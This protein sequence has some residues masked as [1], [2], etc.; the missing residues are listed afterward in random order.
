MLR[1]TPVSP[2]VALGRALVKDVDLRQIPVRTV[3]AERV[4]DELNRFRAAVEGARRE[5]LELK[6]RFSAR[7]EES[8][9]RI[10][11]THLAY[12]KDPVFISD[13]ENAVLNGAMNLESAIAKV[14]SDFDRIFKL[15][16]TDVLRERAMDLRDVAM[17]VLRHLEPAPDAPAGPAER[18]ILVTRELSLAEMFSQPANAWKG[19]VTEEGGVASHAAILA[20]SLRIPTVLGVEGI[21]EK[22]KDGDLVLVD[23]TEGVVR[24]NPEERLILE[25][26]ETAAAPVVEEADADLLLRPAQTADGTAVALLATCGN[27][28]EVDRAKALAMEGVGLYRTEL[29]YLLDRR[30]PSEDVLAEHY[31]KAADLVAPRPISFRLL[32][33]DATARLADLPGHRDPNPALG[34]RSIRML[35]ANPSVFRPQLRALLR[36]SVGRN[37]RVLVPF[38]TDVEEIRLVKEALFQERWDLQKARTP[39]RERL[40]VGALVETPAAALAIRDL[41]REVDLV[42][43]GLDNFIQYMLAA[44]R[45]NA[46][47]R[48]RF[49]V[50]HPVVLR[51][52]RKVRSVTDEAGIEFDLAGEAAAIPEH[53]ALYVGIGARRFS[54]APVHLPE[55]KRALGLLDAEASRRLAAEA[56]RGSGPRAIE[57]LLARH[58]EA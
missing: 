31:A 5:L 24:V 37:V 14:I 39:A 41:V 12:L 9:S 20:R 8:S 2:G 16:E 42:V 36:A 50:P 48:D 32:D 15:V 23:G 43:V 4:E 19:I 53:L 38:V 33:L 51:A 45:G 40:P 1:G 7:I 54:I 6:A 25:Y 27:H 26:E 44:D 13:V 52:L 46:A 58:D 17:R 47:V 30:L 49:A 22:V 29:L 28:A 21:L 10:F 34:V 55:V 35:L 57:L 3:A 11:D 56:A 18:T